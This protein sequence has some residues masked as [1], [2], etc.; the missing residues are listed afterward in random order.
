MKKILISTIF[1]FFTIFLIPNLVLGADA[2]LVTNANLKYDYNLN[3]TG[4]SRLTINFNLAE[5]FDLSQYN[6]NIIID[7]YI[8]NENGELMPVKSSTTEHIYAKDKSW[9]GYLNSYDNYPEGERKY[10]SG[11]A[12]DSR[13]SDI[14][15]ANTNLSTQINSNT[16]VNINWSNNTVLA[17]KVTAIRGDRSGEEV[18]AYSD[19]T[20]ATIR[21][22]HAPIAPV[23]TVSVDTGIKLE[24]VAELPAS[25]Q[26]VA[27]KV[28][29]DAIYN[30]V[31][32]II[33]EAND[34]VIYKIT[35]ESSGVRIQP[36]GKVKINIPIP[37][38]FDNSNVSVFRIEE[39][40]TK[41]EYNVSVIHEDGVD[42][43][44]F[45]TEHFSTYVLAEVLGEQDNTP[46]TGDITIYYVIGIL[47]ISI[48]GIVITKKKTR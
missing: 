39:D 22:I 18:I 2:N 42:Y 7:Y 36:N 34:F 47:F 43:A 10:S 16:K 21:K 6:S 26:L 1:L 20:K 38:N 17:V 5:N 23:A 45:E 35:L 48:I 14:I 30:E 9:A 8:K 11:I 46:I 28:E 12:N 3:G 24:S 37:E 31:S 32:T 4:V 29:D 19:G 27:E 41:R 33:A 13:Y 44:T 40:G 25:T 15:S